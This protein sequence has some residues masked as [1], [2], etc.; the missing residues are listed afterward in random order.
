MKIKIGSPYK[1][2]QFSFKVYDGE[3]EL[4]WD[5]SRGKHRKIWLRYS[6]A[7]HDKRVWGRKGKGQ[8]H[9]C[10]QI[11]KIITL[12]TAHIGKRIYRRLY[13]TR[14]FNKDYHHYSSGES[15]QECP[16]N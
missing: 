11:P 3:V 12:D 13:L 7:R 15:V 16:I 6:N 9:F 5:I 4:Q 14:L 1:S 8:S 2:Y 10:F